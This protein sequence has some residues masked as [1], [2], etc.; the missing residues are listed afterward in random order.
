MGQRDKSTMFNGQRNNIS[1][2]RG[3]GG[4]GWYALPYDSQ[5]E[6]FPNLLATLVTNVVIHYQIINCF[7]FYAHN[8]NKIC[9]ISKCNWCLTN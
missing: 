1:K 7:M 3:G 8:K 9:H 2:D 5:T 4:R 6:Y